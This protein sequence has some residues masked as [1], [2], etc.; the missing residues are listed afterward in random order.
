LWAWINDLGKATMNLLV[1]VMKMAVGAGIMDKV[2]CQSFQEFENMYFLIVLIGIIVLFFIYEY[3]VRRPDHIVLYESN[4]KIALRKGRF[5]PRHF[6]LVLPRTVHSS[7]ISIDA[8]AR[9]NLDVKVRLAI[10]VALSLENLETLIKVGGWNASA[11]EEAANEL[12]T[13]I[14]SIVREFTEKFEIEELSS[15][16]IYNHLNE[17]MSISKDKF[18][19]EVI[20]IA[21]QS[22][23]ITDAKIADAIRQQESARIL[24][25][26]EEL[27]QRGRI[28]A[29]KAKFQADE[30]IALLESQ[31]ELKKFE[32]KK[33]EVEKEA[34]IAKMRVEEELKRKNMQL[35]YERREL[36]LLKNNP[37][38]LILTPQAAR[39]AEASQA[40]R[41]AK[42]VVSLSSK[43]MSFGSELA[44][45]LQN[46]LQ[47]SL[48]ANS[49]KPKEK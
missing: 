25:Q 48:A 32:L 5:Y 47:N 35:D 40:L 23:D 36:E 20:S 42:T 6:S 27:N 7:Q 16:K 14:H 10:S 22:V 30:Q 2:K 37:E 4:G 12:E 3:R 33:A 21:V 17:K 15:E 1:G 34:E 41:N 13:M 18:G 11:T 31:L 29:A 39:L 28:A 8:T 26:T 38:L 49:R 46:F 43:D 19:L 9:G 24:E 44:N 45:A